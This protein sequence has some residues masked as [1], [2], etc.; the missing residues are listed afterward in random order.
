MGD[1][2]RNDLIRQRL[3]V[4]HPNLATEHFRATSPP[5]KG[6]NCFA[7]A[8]HETQRKW[9]PS[10]YGGLFWPGGEQPDTLE[11]FVTGYGALGFE[12]CESADWESGLEKIAIFV[13]DG[14]PSHV[15]RQLPNGMW[16]SKMGDMEDIEHTLAGLTDGKY[17]R[18]HVLM[19]RPATRGQLLLAIEDT[20][21]QCEE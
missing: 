19:Q 11:G 4:N 12:R 8:G 17:G 20:P 21:V 5:D 9:H 14:I 10:A 13:A 7:W 18:V 15:A 1:A 3:S 16:T 6:Y 2:E